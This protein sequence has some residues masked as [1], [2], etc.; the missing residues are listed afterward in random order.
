MAKVKVH[1]LAK[2]LEKQSKE[3]IAFLQNKGIEVK[4]A[5]SS[6][7]EDVADMVRKEF[8][9]KQTS[10]PKAEAVEKKAETAAQKPET[11]SKP[12]KAENT[13]KQAEEQK[14]AAH[15]T[16]AP[17]KKKK[18]IIFVSNPHNSK[19]QGGQRSSM[20]NDRR[21]SGNSNNSG[22]RRPLIRPLTPPSPT[23][24]VD[25]VKSTPQ[26]R[27]QERPQLS[28]DGRPQGV[29]ER[30]QAT[31][32]NRGG[33][34]VQERRTPDNRDRRVQERTGG[35]YDNR[36]RQTDNRTGNTGY[37]RDRGTAQS[38]GDRNRSFNNSG[39][40]ERGN[41]R[42]DNRFRKPAP[43][44]GFAADTPI[45]EVEKP[46]RD[47]GKRRQDQERDKRSR[48]DAIYE[49]GNEKGKGKSNKPGRFIKPEKKVEEKQEEQIKTIT[50]PET[51][52]IKELAD[53]MKIQPSAI[54]KKLFM[55]GQIVTVNQEI[56]FETAEEI[57]IEYEIICEKEVKVDVIEEL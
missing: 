13:P 1:E 37:N 39:R 19:M 27:R 7:E 11:E 56:S 32:D 53:K 30:V 29:Q 57:A 28:Q 2:E 41:G 31:Q 4:A 43:G 23:P 45:K 49:D 42:E 54:V 26:P 36:N 24:S 44:K 46:H 51:L 35:S 18:N 20:G 5:Q 6:V 34:P 12:E 15:K 48:K 55:Q 3:V 9:A 40:P 10:E 38:S 16:E 50:L 47:E 52:T 25:M 22:I 33:R 21:N 17:V 14:H 8:G